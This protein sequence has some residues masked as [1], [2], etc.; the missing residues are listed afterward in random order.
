MRNTPDFKSLYMPFDA[1]LF[2]GDL[3]DGD[4]VGSIEQRH[5]RMNMRL[6]RGWNALIRIHRWTGREGKTSL[7]EV[8]WVALSPAVMERWIVR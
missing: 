3:G 5:T 1:L 8:T 4:L 2:F 7:S 6:D